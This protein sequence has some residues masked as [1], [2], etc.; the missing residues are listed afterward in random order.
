MRKAFRW[1]FR[2]ALAA[3]AAG[4]VLLIVTYL[5]I[6]PDL[7]DVETLK[8]V[9]LKVPLRAYT[10][11]GRLM[12]VYG[13]QLRIPVR[14][15]DVPEN[16]KNG[17]IAGEDARFYDHP[18]VD[19][20]GITRAVITL[21]TTG[22]KTI[23]GS[24]ITQMLARNFFLSLEKTFTR[25]TKEIF[26]AL[27]IERELSKDEILELFLNKIN[28]G[29]RA[30]GVGAAAEV[31]YGKSLDELTLA[32]SA[33]IASL[34]KAPSRI[35]PI[36]SP[37][38]ALERRNY[39]LSR[40]L[41]L[42]Y[43]TSA[44]YKQA[45]AERDTAYRH[46]ATLELSA[47]YLAEMV[48][49]EALQLLGRGASTEGYEIFT[50]VDSSIQQ[51]ATAA[52]IDGLETY[53]RR[54]GYRGPE[55]NVE[56]GEDAT[57]T[58]WESALGPYKTQAGLAPGL[59][60][61][62]DESLA[63]VYLAS[64]QTVALTI[65]SMSWARQFMGRDRLGPRPTEVS[66]VLSTGDIIR[67]RR[68][69]EG[70]WQLAQIPEVEGALV[71]IDPKN[72]ALRALV[73]GYE[74]SRSQFNRV[75][76]SRR[77][78]GS[79]FKPFLYSAALANGFTTASLINDAPIVFEDSELERTWKP[80]NFSQTFFG[81]TRMREAMI[82]SRNLVSIRMLRDLGINT[83][84]N[85][86][87]A[88]GFSMDE[89]PD[90]LS[91]ALGSAN[92]PPLSIARG[93][94]TFAN[95]GFLINPYFIEKIVDVEGEIVYQ[96]QPGLACDDCVASGRNTPAE[97][98][99]TANERPEY[100][101]LKLEQDSES[102]QRPA[103][104]MGLE[105]PP[106][107]TRVVSPQ[108]AYLVRS[109]MM[110]VINRGTGVRAKRELARSDLAGKTGTTNDQSDAW[111]S[112][113]ND[114]LVTTV[115]VGFD[116]PSSLGRDEVGGRAALPIWIA[117]MREALRDVPDIPPALPEGLATA[118]INPETGL[119]ATLE[120]ESAIME[121]FETGT[122]PPMEEASHTL[123]THATPEEDPYDIY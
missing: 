75:T 60:I 117:F 90:N 54:H 115:W 95:G 3:I 52:V 1:I 62:V 35:N 29:H 86:I 69:G 30:Y 13:E 120:N 28:L 41:D 80:E 88:F 18:G 37:E 17:F 57:T 87:S 46:G 6:V 9:R 31:Y 122:L 81:P 96:A 89:L 53:D 49:S 8:E 55:A 83:A 105:T 11:D 7:P 40:M 72:G 78:P 4:L 85:H 24:T 82:N 91:L 21:A 118:R 113:F 15:E 48:R 110:D 63:L 51:A 66:E 61:E 16:I 93:Y 103:V 70:A 25:K 38:R 67:L 12:L 76:Q 100:R 79:S 10:T 101:P 58:D 114:A 68:T 111:F 32:Q 112:G 94:A 27:R 84:R 50:T 119:I 73:G 92:L 47:P 102:A 121:L 23:G 19:Y 99:D 34:A 97:N 116:V 59:V 14:M 104:N 42:G 71:S 22:E 109:M 123:E 64:S 36:T 43:I 77:Q 44:D 74:F 98:A 56:L 106:A 2:L 26:L 39:I 107:A 65:E 108:N 5:I 45:I 33:M 20:Q